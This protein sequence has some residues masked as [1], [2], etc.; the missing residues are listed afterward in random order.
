MG[1]FKPTHGQTETRLYYIWTSMKA[2]CT[3]PRCKSFKHYGGRG[4]R[5]CEEWA[6]S[7]EA[8][9]AWALPNGYTDNLTIDRIDNDKGYDPDNCRWVDRTTQS[10]NRR[11][12]RFLTYNGETRTI[13]EWAE[14]VGIR[15]EVIWHRVVTHG[16]DIEKALLTPVKSYK[17]RQ[18]R[19]LITFNG[20]TKSLNEWSK[21]TGIKA[22]TLYYRIFVYGWSVE[23]AFTTTQ[24]ERATA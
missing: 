22:H 12:N 23:K 19:K 20:S 1:Q 13:G 3:N 18:R 24:K 14:I 5:V 6:Q 15:N 8:F 7:F 17:P 16:W 21:E 9:Q 11:N 4:I 2:R 10:R